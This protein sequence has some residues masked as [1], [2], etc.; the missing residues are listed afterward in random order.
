MTEKEKEEKKISPLGQALEDEGYTGVA[1]YL[2]AFSLGYNGE[3]EEFVD[4]QKKEKEEK[5]N[6]LAELTKR[7]NEF[8]EKI[9]KGN[10]DTQEKLDNLNQEKVQ[11]LKAGKI[12]E[13]N[14]VSNK[15]NNIVNLT[16]KY[17]EQTNAQYGLG[18][19]ENPAAELNLDVSAYD[20]R[21][22][23]TKEIDG[24]K[25]AIPMDDEKINF[26]YNNQANRLEAIISDGTTSIDENGKVVQPKGVGTPY[27]NAVE[28]DVEDV[29]TSNDKP[30]KLQE[31]TQI[32]TNV[33]FDEKEAGALAVVS[34]GTT[35]GSIP[36]VNKLLLDNKKQ[37]KNVQSD[38]DKEVIQNKI[39]ALEDVKKSLVFTKGKA[40]R[41]ATAEIFVSQQNMSPSDIYDDKGNLTE[42]AG[43]IEAQIRVNPALYTKEVKDLEDSAVE[44]AKNLSNL[45]DMYKMMDEG[46]KS[47]KIKSGYLDSTANWLQSKVGSSFV[48]ENTEGAIASELQKQAG[49]DAEIS[50]VLAKTVKAMYGGNASEKDRES[51]FGAMGGL[52]SDDEV[53]RREAFKAFIRGAKKVVNMDISSLEK[54]GLYSSVKLAKEYSNIEFN[55][56]GEI[57]KKDELDSILGF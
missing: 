34:D 24:K 15:M 48:S 57:K 52:A 26:A 22:Y 14:A 46:I 27:M 43:A 54:K 41:D 47:G 29:K 53:T 38:T 17:L 37:L 55:E 7:N 50:L 10:I 3:V 16:A 35:A 49:L 23:T 13:A 56:E 28:I 21:A 20:T 33:G 36:L 18:T 12:E 40:D 1:K 39:N 2:K 6:K 45:K 32:Y 9:A 30:S 25:F 4:R 5:A 31:I 44:G 8:R 19:K 51:I 42:K 11:L